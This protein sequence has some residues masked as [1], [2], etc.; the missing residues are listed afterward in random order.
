VPTPLPT[1]AVFFDDFQV[2]EIP[3]PDTEAP[4]VSNVTALSASELEITFSEAVDEAFIHQSQF[5]VNNQIGNPAVVQLQENNMV[6]RLTFHNTFSNGAWYV[7][8]VSG[9]KDRAG[10]EILP[11]ELPFLFF[12]PV[13]ASWK[14]VIITEIMADPSPPVE[15]PEVEFVELYNRSSH[16]FNL[17]GWRFADDTRTAVLPDYLL[18]PNQYVILSG[19]TA[20]TRLTAFGPVLGVSSF[21]TLNNAGDVLTLKDATGRTIDSLVYRDT[22]Y[23]DPDKKDGGWTL[24]MIDVQNICWSQNN[25]AASTDPSGG[26]P[27]RTNAVQR[28][29]ADTIGPKLLMT[30]ALQ[31]WTSCD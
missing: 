7:V 17:K 31:V 24:E 28:A 27:G 1:Q 18:K 25:W 8:S 21:P 22:W 16:P 12:E 26:T 6:M 11:V 15:L 9:I 3:V 5:S 4:V 30:E 19:T 14:D 10:N 20:A 23:Q 29:N 2:S 13:A